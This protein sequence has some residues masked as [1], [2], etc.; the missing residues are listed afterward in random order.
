MNKDENSPNLIRP[1]LTEF[2]SNEMESGASINIS[3]QSAAIAGVPQCS[4][5]CNEDISNNSPS[6]LITK[7]VEYTSSLPLQLP[8]KSETYLAAANLVQGVTEQP[9]CKPPS[10]PRGTKDDNNSSSK[11]SPSK[12]SVTPVFVYDP[13]KVPVKFIFANRDGI[14][15]LLEFVAE[16]TVGEVKEALIQSWPSGT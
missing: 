16:N 5:Q 9:Q 6:E 1:P 8:L 12:K 4:E 11:A 2:L 3:Q 15:V 7:V 10:K 14:N 13:N